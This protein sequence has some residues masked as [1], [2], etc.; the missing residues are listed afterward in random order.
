MLEIDGGSNGH[1]SGGISVSRT[2]RAT[3]VNFP[4]EDVNQIHLFSN[5]KV[6]NEE[7]CT[8]LKG[9]KLIC[10][11]FV[12]NMLVSEI[13]LFSKVFGGPG[14]L[15]KVRKAGRKHFFL[16]SSNPTRWHRAMYDQKNKSKILCNVFKMF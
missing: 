5:K 9:F 14:G 1:S 6:L 4:Q 10:S 11:Y 12:L 16:F 7:Q 2:T 8:F 13:L 3:P 15:R